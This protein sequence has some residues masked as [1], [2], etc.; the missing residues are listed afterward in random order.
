[1][2]RKTVDHVRT[3]S[4]PPGTSLPGKRRR[5]VEPAI[6]SVARRKPVAVRAALRKARRLVVDED[7]A[8]ALVD[9]AYDVDTATVMPFL[10]ALRRVRDERWRARTLFSVFEHAA[11]Q[12]TEDLPAAAQDAVV[13]LIEGIEDEAARAATLRKLPQRFPAPLR[14]RLAGLAEALTDPLERLR[15]VLS[16]EKGSDS[17]RAGGLLEAARRIADEEKRG[18][19]LAIV[20]PRLNPTQLMDAL[21]VATSIA[22]PG[23]SGQ[24]LVRIARSIPDDRWRERAQLEILERA[25]AIADP[26]CRFDVLAALRDLP[27]ERKRTTESALY[28]LATSFADPS[29]RS[30]ALF[31]AG[32]FADDEILRKKAFLGGIAAA[33]TVLD[34]EVRA[35]LLEALYPVGP[36]LD[37]AVRA[38]V[39]RAVE[40]VPDASLRGRLRSHLG[41]LFVYDRPSPELDLRAPGSDARPGASRLRDRLWDVFIS[42]ATADLDSARSLAFDLK[43]RGLQVFLSADSLDAEV[44]SVAWTAALDHALETSRALLVLLTPSALASKWVAQEWRKYYQLMVEDQ[45]GC[46]LTLRLS[47]PAIAELPLTLRMYQVLDSA[48]GQIE[49]VHITRILD[50]VRG[51]SA[52]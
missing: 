24:A 25:S 19:A 42:Y 14:A 43:S 4:R 34:M 29:V 40:R 35:E 28:E 5:G 33:E 31:I 38:E 44:G 20:A 45:A 23:V 13:S 37:P 52:S 10:E 30:R 1:M 48:T 27:V 7:L 6:V 9:M 12:L 50:L 26:V 41:R 17:A 32:D 22:D 11:R 49:P 2:R 3:R 21:A 39:R 15:T 16:Y 8:V 51:S 18:E 36:W 46:L 47:G